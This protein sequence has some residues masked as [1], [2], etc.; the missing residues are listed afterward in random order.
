[1]ADGT[2]GYDNEAY[3]GDGDGSGKAKKYQ[4]G[5]HADSHRMTKYDKAVLFGII[6]VLVAVVAITLIFAVDWTNGD[7]GNM[8]SRQQGSTIP[9]TT[10]MAADMT[11]AERPP[12][13]DLGKPP[14][15]VLVLADDV[16]WNDVGWNN[17]FM[18][19][20][21][22]NELASNG[23][24]LNNTY[25][26]PACSPSR[27]ALLTGKY[28]A[29]AGIQHLVV[30]EQHPYYLPLHNT[31]LSTKLKELG[32]MNHAIG[33]WHLGFC[34]WKYTPLWRGFD[35][36]YGIFNGYLSDYSTHIVHS[37]FIGEPGASGL[38][39]RDNTG[40]VAHENGTHVTYLFTE[41]AER[42]IRNHNPAAPL[43]LYTAL[44]VPHGPLDAPPGFENSVEVND[45]RRR[46]YAGM[47]SAMDEAV[48]NITNA[49][50]D[51]GMWNDTLFIFLSDNGGDMFYAGNNY[52]FRGNKASLW[53]GS[54][55]IPGFIYGNMLEKK[56]YS[57][58]ELIHFTDLFATLLSA[59]GGTPDDDIDG[60]NQWDTVCRGDASKRSEILLHLD[61]FEATRGAALRMNDYKYI[62]GITELVPQ[63]VEA[64]ER[65]HLDQWYVPAEHPDAPIPDAP[66]ISQN[67]NNTFLFNLRDDPLETTNLA[68]DPEMQDILEE[69]QA[70]LQYYKD[71]AAPLW[72]PENID[73]SD[74]KY[75]DGAW[76]PGWC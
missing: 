57:N 18:P 48:G 40:V 62:E 42:I 4:Q 2:V 71:N 65:F 39:L 43:F 1:M 21:I 8:D 27:A 52:P 45:T 6:I 72:Y 7:D 59:A 60:I 11:T 3:V 56:G 33:K 13:G 46:E 26:Q 54:V 14:H 51:K 49:L 15:I 47:I 28:P 38:D 75:F 55:K 58:N 76:T 36:F 69:M 70:R 30:Q 41:R 25:S 16:G 44:L 12:C 64:H 24:I 10:Q 73:E 37:P 29:N 53:E 50:K 20:P 34:N 5:D 23:V 67:V 19:T 35:S 9:P 61:T 17:D 74:P 63:R 22:L 31:L 68:T 66:L 32:Y